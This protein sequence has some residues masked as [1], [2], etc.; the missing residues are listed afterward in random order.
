MTVALADG[1]GAALTV[2]AGAELTETATAVVV[3]VTARVVTTTEVVVRAAVVV[4]V[5]TAAGVVVTGAAAVVSGAVLATVLWAPGGV[6][7]TPA[8]AQSWT[9]NWVALSKS[10]AEQAALMAGMSEVRK[11]VFLHTQAMSVRP[12]P[13]EPRAAMA[14]VCCGRRMG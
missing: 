5:V 13:V 9:A 1:R 6:M 2:V 3:P 11:A 4:T 10:E 7:V 12:Q 8:E 14:G